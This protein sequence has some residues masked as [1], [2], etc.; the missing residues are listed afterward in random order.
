L[1][2]ALLYDHKYFIMN[3]FFWYTDDAF[4]HAIYKSFGLGALRNFARNK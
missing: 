1:P 2:S 3:F 4:R